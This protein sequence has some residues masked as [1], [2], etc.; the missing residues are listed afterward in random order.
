MFTMQTLE[1]GT[2]IV[3]IS[4]RFEVFMMMDFWKQYVTYMRV[5]SLGMKIMSNN[6]MWIIVTLHMKFVCWYATLKFCW[7]VL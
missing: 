2:M 6:V 7:I 4:V 3:T 5:I 1:F